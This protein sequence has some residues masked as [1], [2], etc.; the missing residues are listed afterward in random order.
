MEY[1]IARVHLRGLLKA[2]ETSILPVVLLPAIALLVKLKSL[3]KDVQ[4][5][6]Y[7]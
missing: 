2:Q 7:T 1:G 4:F 6:H 5:L 3:A